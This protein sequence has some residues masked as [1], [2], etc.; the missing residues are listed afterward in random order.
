M[1]FNEAMDFW[2]DLSRD[3]SPMGAE[4]LEAAISLLTENTGWSYDALWDEWHKQQN[5]GS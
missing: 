1:E 3:N 4:D 2:L 5:Y